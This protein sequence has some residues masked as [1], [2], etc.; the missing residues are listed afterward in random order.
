MDDRALYP[1]I[2]GLQAP[3]EVER[4][5]LRTDPQEVDVWVGAE[6]G[7]S[8]ACPHCGQTAPIYDHVERRWRHV[9][10]CQFR[11][12]LCAR[13]PRLRCAAHGVITVPVPWA[14]TGSRFTL[15]FERLAIAWLQEATPTAV[16]RR[17][18][19]SWDEARGIME[20]AVRRG[21]QHR[22]PTVVP[23]LG[24]DERSFLK[25]HQYVS[26]V[27]DLDTPRILHV[28]D[29]RKAASLTGDFQTL[30]PRQRG[31]I[32]DVAARERTV[33]RDFEK[34]PCKRSLAIATED[35][36]QVRI[37]DRAGRVR[38]RTTP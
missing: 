13:P 8:F 17:L 25:R 6:A 29:D 34:G 3:W 32:P 24:V 4:V 19:L 36:T 10:T 11:T 20:R 5:E 27:A 12:L 15:L 18:G 31:G 37:V 38:W 35:T 28:A 23:H 26:V 9:D 16:G 30:T 1:T 14:E 33:T 22:Q 21:L 7:T 2:L